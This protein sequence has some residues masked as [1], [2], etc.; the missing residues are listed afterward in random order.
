MIMTPSGQKGLIGFSII[1]NY[2]AGRKPGWDL[3]AELC[4]LT[5]RCTKSLFR[6]DQPPVS[7]DTFQTK[8]PSRQS[9][10][11]RQGSPAKKGNPPFCSELRKP[12]GHRDCYLNC[13]VPQYEPFPLTFFCFVF[14]D[15][16]VMIKWCQIGL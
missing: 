10:R 1:P 7:R 4:S 16:D 5:E 3:H 14:V 12:S 15:R 9:Q 13:K 2:P 11:Q 6:Q 8:T